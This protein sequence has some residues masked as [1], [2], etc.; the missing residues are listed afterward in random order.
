MPPVCGTI[1]FNLCR[2]REEWFPKIHTSDS[3]KFW[4]GSYF[5]CKDIPYPGEDSGIPPFD[6]CAA[7]P[8][9]NWA[10][11]AIAELPADLLRIKR[12]ISKM[13]ASTPPLTGMDTVLC[14]HGRRIQPLSHR[15]GHLLCTYT[16][17]D[18]SMRGTKSGMTEKLF[19]KRINHLVKTRTQYKE[20]FEM[21]TTENPP[22]KVFSCFFNKSMLCTYDVCLTLLAMFCSLKHCRKT[23]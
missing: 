8:Q 5:Y 2:F 9:D 17:P 11:D 4:T 7:T 13:V 16:G 12:R 23:S 14:W 15:S 19:K 20:S 6:N 10:L 1:T 21:F 22:P 18:D 3:V